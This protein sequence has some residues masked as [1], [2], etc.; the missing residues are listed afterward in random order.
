MYADM[1]SKCSILASIEKLYNIFYGY[2]MS[3][4]ASKGIKDGRLV[5]PPT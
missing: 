3:L 2:L 4:S 1:Y 5:I